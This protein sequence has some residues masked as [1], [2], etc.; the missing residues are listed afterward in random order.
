MNKTTWAVVNDFTIRGDDGGE[1]KGKAGQTVELTDSET[2]LVMRSFGPNT[3][4]EVGS[5]QK[6]PRPRQ[7]PKRGQGGAQEPITAKEAAAVKDKEK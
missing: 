5:V 2:S 1:I 4:A 3:I 6:T 7:S